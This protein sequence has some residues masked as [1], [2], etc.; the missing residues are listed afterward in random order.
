MGRWRYIESLSLAKISPLK[1]KR[2][3][4]T[5]KQ[6]DKRDPARAGLPIAVNDVGQVRPVLQQEQP[7]CL[8][9]HDAYPASACA[10]TRSCQRLHRG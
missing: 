1:K 2:K 10:T 3:Q 9:A 7:R 8:F 5:S 4:G 6:N